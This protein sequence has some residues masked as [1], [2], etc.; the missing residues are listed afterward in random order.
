MS[1]LKKH[2]Q[3]LGLQDGASQ[4]EIQGAYEHLSDT[5]D[6]KKNDNLDFFIE[7]YA[8]VQEAFLN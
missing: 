6:P 2:Y 4:E 3:T 1:K 7:E 8:L 5:L